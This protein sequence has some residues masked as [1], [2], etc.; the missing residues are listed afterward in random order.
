[1]W[2]LVFLFLKLDS[3]RQNFSC[4]L[5]KK[6]LDPIPPKISIIW[7]FD[8]FSLGCRC[9]RVIF[10]STSSDLWREFNL[11]NVARLILFLSLFTRIRAKKTVL[12]Q[13]LFKKIGYDQTT[14]ILINIPDCQWDPL[15]K[16]NSI[17][18]FVF[19]YSLT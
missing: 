15:L 3:N 8:L 4:T 13:S 2:I 5:K 16:L 11:L 17:N 10:W 7:T 14:W 1:M 18:N 12:N 6:K 19:L 9:T